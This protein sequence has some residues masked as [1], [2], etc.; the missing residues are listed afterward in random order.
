MPE[1]KI[2][3]KESYQLIRA[4]EMEFIKEQTILSPIN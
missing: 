3:D 4:W 2:G 1:A